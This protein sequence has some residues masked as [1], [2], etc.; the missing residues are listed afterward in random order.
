MS[1]NTPE[2]STAPS[3]DQFV[4]PLNV[5]RAGMTR[6]GYPDDVQGDLVWFVGYVREAL[7]GSSRAAEEAVGYSYTTIYRILRGQYGAAI[8][9]FIEAV[10]RL[11]RRVK[12]EA[13]VHFVETEVTRRVWAELD[14]CRDQNA[15][16]HITGPTGRGKTAVVKQW[17]LANNH[18]RAV[19]I[20]VPVISGLR[21][22]LVE[23]AKAS[24]IGQGRRTADLADRVQAAFDH[25]NVIVLDEVARLV[26]NE[27]HNVRCLEFLRRL[28]DR[29][30]VGL[31]FIS[32]PQFTD[33]LTSG[34]LSAY[35]EQFLGRMEDP[36]RLPANL[37]AAEAAAIAAAFAGQAD[38]EL[39][40]MIIKVE[41]A[42]G[43]HLRTLYRL[44]RHA[45]LL[46]D[47]RNERVT[48]THL[49]AAI[50]RRRQRHNWE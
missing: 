31:A 28:H 27:G 42:E 24:G 48:I 34:R 16:I 26:P 35:L 22:L 4:A 11:R 40:A 12:V 20:D 23:M 41:R 36:L 3:D 13:G 18:G 5:I 7:N 45:K 17:Q 49:A 6:A 2:A 25:R 39:A 33:D 1:Q 15:M 8:D 19:Y 37:L 46:A 10:R 47:S 44:L 14:Y 38:P 32:T 9:E 30:R 29:Q 50:K 43:G 21:A